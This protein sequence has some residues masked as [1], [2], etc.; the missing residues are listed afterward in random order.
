MAM[1]DVL[2]ETLRLRVRRWRPEDR[3]P[4]ARMNADPRVMRHFPA[5]LSRAE[6]DAF[7][8][9]LQEREARDG[10]VFPALERRSDDAFVGFAGLARAGFPAH[11]TPAV[12]IGWR[13]PPDCWGQGYATEAALAALDYGFETLGVDEIVS[14]TAVGNRP[15]R[16]VMERLAM[17]HDAAGD[18]DHPALDA[19]SPLLR[20]VLYRITRPEWEAGD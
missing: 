2:Y 4:L 1:T 6:S 19:S 3:A 12:E 5:T 13:L 15:S 16:A 14:F 17:T 9:R 10:F 20:H 18:F 7:Y 8:D 11:F